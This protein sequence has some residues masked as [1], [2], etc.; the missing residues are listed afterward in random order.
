M[1]ESIGTALFIAC[2]LYAAWAI[3]SLGVVAYAYCWAVFEGLLV[4]AFGP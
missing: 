2:G 1:I 3:L 4:R